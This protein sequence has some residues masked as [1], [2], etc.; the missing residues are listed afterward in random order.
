MNIPA[1][2]KTVE[3]YQKGVPTFKFRDAMLEIH[4]PGNEAIDPQPRLIHCLCLLINAAFP[5]RNISEEAMRDL[6]LTAIAGKGKKVSDNVLKAEQIEILGIC[7][8]GKC[9]TVDC[10]IRIHTT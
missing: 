4:L 7:A 1:L 6:I 8:D 2:Q 3:A 10:Y 5:S 9:N